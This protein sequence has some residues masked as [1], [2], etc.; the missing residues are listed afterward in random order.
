[1]SDTLSYDKAQLSPCVEWP[2]TKTTRGYGQKRHDGRMQYVTRLIWE[3]VYDEKIPDGMHVC[4]KCDNPSCYTIEHLF[5]GTR[6]QNMQDAIDKGR[7][8][9]I[10]S[11]DH[12]EVIRRVKAGEMYA[13]I[14]KDFEVDKQ[15][16]QKQ[17][18]KRGL[19]RYDGKNIRIAAKRIAAQHRYDVPI[20]KNL[21]CSDVENRIALCANEIAAKMAAGEVVKVPRRRAFRSL[22]PEEQAQALKLLKAGFASDLIAKRFGVSEKTIQRFAMVNGVRRNSGFRPRR[23][24]LS[25]AGN[26]VARAAPD[27]A[28][29]AGNGAEIPKQSVWDW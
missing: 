21:E 22:S 12:E 13:D 15:S 20:L 29:L 4:H 28:S 5:L 8:K 18:A 25:L 2:G 6:S 7:R 26:E 27:V 9:G 19:Y 11:G 24:G 10:R 16:V 23:D 3:A 17:A 1:M 14:A